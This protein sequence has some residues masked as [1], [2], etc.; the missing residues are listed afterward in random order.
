[1]DIAFLSEQQLESV[2]DLFCEMS[3]HY[4]GPNASDRE[5][6]KRNLV[7]NILAKD[8]GVRLVIASESGRAIGVACI[9]LLYPAPKERGQLFL[10]ELYVS[11]SWR[12]RGVGR[13]LM[14]YA[15]RYAVEKSCVRFD[16]T[17]DDSNP[18][19]IEFYRELGATHLTSK[20]YFRFSGEDLLEFA[21]NKKVSST[22][23][24]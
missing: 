22:N 12:N 7:N 13:E 17:V 14:R 19:A 20:L 18:K 6:V 21:A 23:D 8:S 10:K 11:S 9:S 2:V 15:A 3:V 4:N 1:M 5:L 24:S 16:W